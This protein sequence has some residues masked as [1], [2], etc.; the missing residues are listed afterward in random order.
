MTP[1]QIK[2]VLAEHISTWSDFDK[3]SQ[4]Q[5]HVA[6][7]IPVEYPVGWLGVGALK[8]TARIN[9]V[10]ERFSARARALRFRVIYDGT[11]LR[12]P[13]II[14]A[15]RGAFVTKDLHYKG[16]HISYDGYL[17]AGHGG[18][19]PKELQGI[20]I[21]I[22]EAAVGE[23]QHDL[24]D[25]PAGRASLLQ[26]WVSG[27]IYAG[28]ELEDAM[29][30]DRS[31]LRDTHP[32]YV[33]LRTSFHASLLEFLSEVRTKLYQAASIDRK[34]EAAHFVGT[35][36]V[37]DLKAMAP[38]RGKGTPIGEAARIVSGWLEDKPEVLVRNMRAADL[39][40]L[41]IKV[42]GE[43][44][45]PELAGQLLKALAEGLFSQQPRR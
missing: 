44:L 37:S 30:I 23:Y 25:F 2:D 21:R 43:V 3:Y 19:E 5:L 1:A 16:E 31:T 24:L 28:D 7:N 9:Q 34:K 11:E 42:A 36:I 26:R 12:K 14:R 15:Q 6:L 38:S 40:S 17:F 8:R 45:P 32:A 18:V 20:L 4:T 29:N 27:E 33:E 10:Q 35:Q 41:V 39:Y 13:T 22:R